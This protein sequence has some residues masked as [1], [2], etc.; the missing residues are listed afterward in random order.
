MLMIESLSGDTTIAEAHKSG[1]LQ[2]TKYSGGPHKPPNFMVSDVLMSDIKLATSSLSQPSMTPCAAWLSD[3]DRLK[4]QSFVPHPTDLLSLGSGFIATTVSHNL[5][6]VFVLLMCAM[7]SI[8]NAVERNIYLIISISDVDGTHFLVLE[9]QLLSI[10]SGN[11]RIVVVSTPLAEC[12]G[13]GAFLYCNMCLWSWPK[14]STLIENLLFHLRAAISP[15][16][17]KLLD[18]EQ[19]PVLLWL[20]YLKRGRTS[21][22]P[23][24]HEGRVGMAQSRNRRPFPLILASLLYVDR[25]M[26][27]HLKDCYAKNLRRP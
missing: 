7:R 23:G 10:Q 18:F 9:H 4:Y 25:L 1:L 3:F 17:S 22:V 2:L 12:C 24:W 11:D 14:R 26:G 16:T 15:W 21:A 8:I 6:P 5:G 19:F 20:C 13:V 27:Q